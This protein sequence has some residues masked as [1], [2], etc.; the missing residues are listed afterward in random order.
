[1]RAQPD[2]PSIWAAEVSPLS[3]PL[4]E[5]PRPQMVRGR[6]AVA[7]MRE[8]G[9]PEN[10]FNLNGLWEWEPAVDMS[11]P[12]GKKLS[13]SILVPFPV[14][15]CLSGVA[16]RSS[17]E[18]VTKMWYRLVFD[19][20][21]TN[22]TRTL[23]HFGAVDWQTT[24]YLNG[25]ML[26]N[27]TG[28]YDGF[29]FE[30]ELRPTGNELLLFV[31]DPSDGGNQPNGK[32][33]ISAI[34]DPGGDTYTPSSGIWQTVW[35]ESVPE[36]YISHLKINQASTSEVSV[37]AELSAP[38]TSSCALRSLLFHVLDRTGTVVANSSA[39][40]CETVTITIPEAHTWS[41]RSAYL[42]D[43]EVSMVG[44][45]KVL[46]YFGLRTFSLGDGHKV[47]RPLLNGEFTF[48]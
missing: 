19:T 35:I 8:T 43:L 15:S 10:W 21:K 40:S 47:K 34:D 27:H 38:S 7:R 3:T 22:G 37:R 4:K 18:I 28:G 6:G 20:V 30:L 1:M 9:D 29:T 25:R 13:F 17:S 5:Y 31:Y 26:G 32:Q 39:K 44:G 36:V 48:L 14:E 46:A 41:P 33:R 23:L 45:D 24:A 12:F 11:P 16:P 2:I 42:Y